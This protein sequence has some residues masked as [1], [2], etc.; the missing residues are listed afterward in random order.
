MAMAASH[1]RRRGPQDRDVS[2]LIE[3]RLIRQFIAVAEEL[4]F[5]RAAERLHMSQPPLS[6]AIRK[7]EADI[8]SPLFI[9]TNRQVT[10]TPAGRAFLETARRVLADLDD[11]IA[12]TRR[13]AEGIAGRLALGFIALGPRPLIT[14]A[15]GRFRQRH[16]DVE[17]S[18]SE[19]TTAEQVEAL[20]KGELDLGFMRQPGAAGAGLATEPIQREAIHVALPAGHSSDT[21]GPVSLAALAGEPFVMSARRLGPSFHDQLIALCQHAGF[22]PRI[23]QEGRQMQTL[24]GLVAAGFGVALVPASVVD[25]GRADV[26]FRPLDVAAPPALTHVDLLM[27]WDPARAAPVRDRFMAEVR[28]LAAAG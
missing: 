12:H 3:T 18:L 6:Q 19:A 2:G 9:R 20:A 13:V 26:V 23:T 22:S 11:G 15:L 1:D 24:V 8:G 17:F 28:A 10:L 16:P 21:G 7:L 25:P 14:G 27:A 4:N 5:H